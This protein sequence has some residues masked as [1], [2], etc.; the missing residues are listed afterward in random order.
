MTDASQTK[1]ASKPRVIKPSRKRDITASDAVI[2]AKPNGISPRGRPLIYSEAIADKVL[3]YLADGRSLRWICNQKHMPDGSTIRKWLARVPDFA[4]QYA[5]ARD[6][7]ADTLFDETLNIADALSDK[8]TNEQIRKAQLQI[9]T[10]KWLVGKLRPKKYGDQLKHAGDE[11]TNTLVLQTV[12]IAKLDF[13]ER[14]TLADM[15]KAIAP[16][17]DTDTL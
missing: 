8:S 17:S 3:D 5:Y 11:T 6:Q 13:D 15:L 2:I 9:D 10:R 12:N 4:K 7:Q 16:A 1:P 14:E